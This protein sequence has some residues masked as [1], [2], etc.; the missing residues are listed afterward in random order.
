MTDYV[1]AKAVYVFATVES[2]VSVVEL[3]TLDYENMFR[4]MCCGVKTLG[5]WFL[6][7]LLQFTQLYK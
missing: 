3:R 6:S 7:A 1:S 5:K 4:V 2:N